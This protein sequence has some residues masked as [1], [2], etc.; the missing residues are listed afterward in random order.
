MFLHEIQKAADGA[1]AAKAAETIAVMQATRRA[2]P[3][4]CPTDHRWSARA[5]E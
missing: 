2:A 3:C 4:C 1:A 5:P